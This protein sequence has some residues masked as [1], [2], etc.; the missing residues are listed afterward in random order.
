M[1]RITS[2]F[3]RNAGF[4][5]YTLRLHTVLNLEVSRKA[6]YIFFCKNGMEYRNNQLIPNFSKYFLLLKRRIN[7]FAYEKLERI[8]L[9]MHNSALVLNIS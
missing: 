4:C 5:N 8:P 6:S 1:V 9:T 2:W 7:V 3:K